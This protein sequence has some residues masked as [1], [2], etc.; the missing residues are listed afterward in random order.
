M[1]KT[2]TEICATLHKGEA[3]VLATIIGQQGSTPRTAGA[4]M[5]VRRDGSIAG[6]IGG[7]RVE[8]DVIAQALRLF[9]SQQATLAQFDLSEAGD[10]DLVCGGALRVCIE[11]LAPNSENLAMLGRMH[12][13]SRQGRACLWLGKLMTDGEQWVVKRSVRSTDGTWSGP[14]PVEP[15]LQGQIGAISPRLSTSTLLEYAG[16]P[17]LVT[18]VRPAETVCLM[19]AGHVS[20]EIALL[21]K[22]VDFRT[23]VFDDRNEFANVENFPAAD[24]VYVCDD[25]RQVFDDFDIPAGSYIVIVTRGHHHDKDVLAQALR[26]EAAYIGMIGSRRKKEAVYRALTEGGFSQTDL[27]RV[28]CPIGLPIGAD[29]PAE[30]AVSVVAELVQH[31][32]Q[33]KQH[34]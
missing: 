2:V 3:L 18:S 29:T 8:S 16:E 34:G 12:E 15:S 5:L 11:Y 26:S 13:E 31:R 27:Q 25:F 1:L 4:S 28:H 33:R 30:I 24:G 14:L 23:L 17:Y 19:G 20:K 10:M 22:Q 21:T 7:G 32:A 9:E 6:T